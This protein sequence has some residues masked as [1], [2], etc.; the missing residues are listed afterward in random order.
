M[1]KVT[2]ILKGSHGC[3]LDELTFHIR[4]WEDCAVAM[5]SA[6]AKAGWV[7]SPGDSI[8]VDGVG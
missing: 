1:I 8:H 7:L 3:E 2:V 4:D 6:M 5:S